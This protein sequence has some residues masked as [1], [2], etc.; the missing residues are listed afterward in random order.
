M[1][2]MHQACEAA[3]CQHFVGFLTLELPSSIQ[4]ARAY[5]HLTG[6]PINDILDIPRRRAEAQRRLDEIQPEIGL[7][8]MAEMAP[9]ATTVAD[10]VLWVDGQEQMRGVKMDVLV[11]DYA[12]KLYAPEVKGNSEYNSM[13]H[14]YEGIRRDIADKRAMWTIT[15]CQATRPQNDAGK[16]IDLRHA[17]DSI[18]KVRVAD[19]VW[20]LNPREDD[21]ML[22][23]YVAKNRLG[24]SGFTVGPL[25]TD[26]E[27]AR[28]VPLARELGHW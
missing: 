1:A 17:S 23:I 7:F 21:G 3:K 10:L 19:A 2:L 28:L 14:V 24:K 5:A 22:D 8:V 20:T 25:M 16:R 15:G 4:W 9:Y 13:R 26:L 6:V 12:D 18:H 11:I 27:R